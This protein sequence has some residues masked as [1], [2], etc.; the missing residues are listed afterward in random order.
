VGKTGDILPYLPALCKVLIAVS[1]SSNLKVYLES[2]Y[3]PIFSPSFRGNKDMP[4]SPLKRLVWKLTDLTSPSSSQTRE[5]E[6]HPERRHCR[7]PPKINNELQS[8]LSSS[9]FSE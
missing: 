8:I 4:P 9:A 5:T 6:F 2:S 3:D 7:F 1:S